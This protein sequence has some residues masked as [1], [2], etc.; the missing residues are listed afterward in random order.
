[1]RPM[2]A[3]NIER[4]LVA[5]G[6]GGPNTVHLWWSTEACPR[7]NCTGNKLCIAITD[8]ITDGTFP[9]LRRRKLCR[10]ANRKPL[11]II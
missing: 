3:I 6:I 11:L 1:M 10:C 2:L 9:L 5:L 8:V 4:A 7:P